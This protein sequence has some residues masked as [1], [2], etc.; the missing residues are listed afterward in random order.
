MKKKTEKKLKLNKE[1]MRVLTNREARIAAGGDDLTC[2]SACLGSCP[3]S[4][5]PVCGMDAV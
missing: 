4:G 2:E 5:K 1:T 3:T